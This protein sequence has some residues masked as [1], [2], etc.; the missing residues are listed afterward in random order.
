VIDSLPD[1]CDPFKYYNTSKGALQLKEEVENSSKG[2][3]FK[4]APDDGFW[5]LPVEPRHVSLWP[6]SSEVGAQHIRDDWGP[7]YWAFR[8]PS[9]RVP[10]VTLERLQIFLEAILDGDGITH[11]PLKVLCKPSIRSNFAMLHIGIMCQY[12]QDRIGEHGVQL[13]RDTR[14]QPSEGQNDAMKRL[15]LCLH[16]EVAPLVWDLL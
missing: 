4:S 16:D 15:F 11:D 1:H 9:S 7:E 10:K 2:V 5:V 8:T 14:N 12:G 13:S 3:S 6:P